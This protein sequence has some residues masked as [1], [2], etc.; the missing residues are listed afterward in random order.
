MKNLKFL[1]LLRTLEKKE[2]SVFYKYLKQ[3]HRGEAI[4]L[5]VFEYIRRFYPSFQNEKKLELTYAYQQIFRLE[6][7]DQGEERRN[8]QKNLLNTLSN[9][10]I[11]LR[12]FLLTQKISGDSLGSQALW[13]RIL[14]E[15]GLQV[16]FSKQA[17]SLYDAAKAVSQ[18]STDGYLMEMMASHFYYQDLSAVRPVPDKSA[19]QGC[20]AT[21]KTCAE[22]IQ[23]KMDCRIAN[24][25]KVRPPSDSATI[26]SIELSQNP[27][28]ETDPL[29]LLY[30]NIRQLVVLEQEEYYD[31]VKASLNALADQLAPDELHS[32]ISYLHNYAAIQIR[33][34]NAAIYLGEVHKLN[35]FGLKYRVFYQK[36]G[37]SPTQFTNIL[38]AACAAKDF[39]WATSF[40]EDHSH[41]LPIN[42]QQDSVSL[43]RAIIY[44]EQEQ[45]E[46]ALQLIASTEFRDI[47]HIIR[48]RL[49]ML[50]I[51]I[52]LKKDIDLILDYCA[53]FEGL[54]GR[55]PKPKTAAVEATL[56]FIQIVKLLMLEK[57]DQ[58]ALIDLIKKAPHLYYRTW[59]LEQAANYKDRHSKRNNST[60]ARQSSGG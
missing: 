20:L 58:Q 34:G 54:L 4:A 25:E 12:D 42:V 60:S 49:I 38:N 17:A 59:S 51:Y 37:I 27:A 32:I 36:E 23:I 24:L 11:W 44:F 2:V 48:S 33:D 14:Q 47:H 55:T 10:H 35:Q 21:W 16:E 26:R 13:L 5:T 39:A 46:A 18:K 1:T 29:L 43:A 22:I 7:P 53:A 6:M 50:R 40:I 30:R 41:L 45:Y 19:L 3:M 15:R 28:V 8:A 57:I 31:R 56:G 52:E 9:L